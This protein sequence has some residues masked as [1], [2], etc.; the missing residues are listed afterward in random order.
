MKNTQW[1]VN[2]RLVVRLP[3]GYVECMGQCTKCKNIIFRIPIRSN[4]GKYIDCE[5]DIAWDDC[6]RN[7][8]LLLG[9]NGT[10]KLVHVKCGGDVKLVKMNG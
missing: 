4:C 3:D 1:Y 2:S 5:C 7:E 8:L 6:L 9:S 10:E